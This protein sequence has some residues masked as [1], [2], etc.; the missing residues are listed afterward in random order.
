MSA[1]LA[2]P[3]LAGGRQFAELPANKPFASVRARLAELN[4]ATLTRF[5][6]ASDHEDAFI[7]FRYRDHEFRIDERFGK[8]RLS[9]LTSQCPE[10]VIY[11]VLQHF[12][13]FLSPGL[14]E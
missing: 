7:T 2:K 1:T 8:L 11:D 10:R 4:G 13:W 14:R 6:N 5:A 3:S 9:V 12:S